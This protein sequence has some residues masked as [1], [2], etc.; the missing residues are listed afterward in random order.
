LDKVKIQ[1]VFKKEGAMKTNISQKDPLCLLL[2][3]LQLNYGR[4]NSLDIVAVKS[5]LVQ[6]SSSLRYAKG[7]SRRYREYF[8]DI[9]DYVIAEYER[10]ELTGGLCS[11]DFML[12]LELKESI[13]QSMLEEFLDDLAHVPK[14][15]AIIGVIHRAIGIVR[16]ADDCST[17]V[18]HVGS[19]DFHD[20][21]DKVCDYVA[22]KEQIRDEAFGRKIY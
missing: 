10:T 3:D 17:Y 15:V 19:K 12:D 4:D 5:S 16:M 9:F 2:E 6:S 18:N 20:L 14:Y 7:Q 11:T 1:L 22:K 21:E 13:K 8:N